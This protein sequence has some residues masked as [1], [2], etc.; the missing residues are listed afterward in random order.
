MKIKRFHQDE[1]NDWIASLSCGHQRHVRHN[2]PLSYYPWVMTKEG[3]ERYIGIN[4]ECM[5]CEKET[6]EQDKLALT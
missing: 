6:V 1:L 3:R 5:L 2:P 4:I